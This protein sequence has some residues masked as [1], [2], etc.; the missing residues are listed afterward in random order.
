MKLARTNWLTSSLRSWHL[1]VFIFLS[2]CFTGLISRPIESRSHMMDGPTPAIFM[3][4]RVNTSRLLE[5][6][7]LNCTFHLQEDLP[8]I[9][10][11]APHVMGLHRPALRLPPIDCLEFLTHRRSIFLSPTTLWLLLNGNLF[12]LFLREVTIIRGHS[13]FLRHSP[14]FLLSNGYD[15]SGI[16]LT[17]LLCSWSLEEW[18]IVK[19][20]GSWME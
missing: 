3:G 20:D 17:L 13:R 10:E 15:C 4:D 16:L 5:K 9:E 1:S 12:L 18:D 6:N 2:F 14:E 8:R 7:S 11:L 19:A